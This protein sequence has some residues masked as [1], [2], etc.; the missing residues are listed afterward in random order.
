[1]PRR[2][3]FSFAVLLFLAHGMFAESIT[4]ARTIIDQAFELNEDSD[5]FGTTILPLEDGK[6]LIGGTHFSG[7]SLFQAEENGA[8]DDAFNSNLRFDVHAMVRLKDGRIAVASYDYAF[9]QTG[10]MV[11]RF[12]LSLHSKT[13]QRLRLLY[14]L[15]ALLE[16][17]SFMRLAPLANGGF[18]FSLSGGTNL[19]RRYDSE[20]AATVLNAPALETDR[21]ITAIAANADNSI[22][23]GGFLESIPGFRRPWLWR[24]RP[25]GSRD[26]A[27]PALEPGT[28]DS[29]EFSGILVQP[30]GKAI[31]T[32]DF[33]QLGSRSLTGLARLNPDGTFDDSLDLSRLETAFDAGSHRRSAL[34][35][36]DSFVVTGL[37]RDGSLPQLGFYRVRIDGSVEVFQLDAPFRPIDVQAIAPT[38]DNKIYIIS[39]SYRSDQPSIF[40]VFADGHPRSAIGLA[41]SFL[42]VPETKGRVNV[43]LRRFG[44]TASA[45]EVV[46]ESR[47]K[48]ALAGVHH[49][50]FTNVVRFAPGESSKE[51]PLGLIDDGVISENPEREMVLEVTSSDGRVFVGDYAQLNVTIRDADHPS[52]VDFTFKSPFSAARVRCVGDVCNTES[53]GYARLDS[54]GRI[55]T[56]FLPIEPAPGLVSTNLLLRLTSTGAIER[57]AEIRFSNASEDRRGIEAVPDG[58]LLIYGPL[59]NSN[60]VRIP[61]LVRL[62]EEL[63][64]DPSFTP[65]IAAAE[66]VRA[67]AVLPGGSFIVATD[68][69]R[70]L[71]SSLQRFHA[72]GERDTAFNPATSFGTI[73]SVA[74][75]SDGRVL[76]SYHNIG[77]KVT[78]LHT[79][80]T[81]D[82]TFSFTT[83]NAFWQG[84][85]DLTIGPD[86]TI[87]YNGSDRL[88]RR[89]PNGR[90]DNS[91]RFD[92]NGTPRFGSDGRLFV[93]NHAQVLRLNWD[94]SP[95]A[96]FVPVFS[97]VITEG[98]TDMF[99]DAED[100]PVVVGNF[101]HAGGEL[102]MQIA[103]LN[104]TNTLQGLGFAREAFLAFERGPAFVVVE[105]VADVREAASVKYRVSALPSQSPQNYQ[106]IEG[107]IA[108]APL[109]RR[110]VV[111]LDLA[112]HSMAE[113]DKVLLIQLHGLPP[114]TN[115]G[116]LQAILRILDDDRHRDGLHLAF[117]KAENPAHPGLRQGVHALGVQSDGKILALNSGQYYEESILRLL[118]SGEVDSEFET[119]A[120]DSIDSVHLMPDGKFLVRDYN[121]ISRRNADGT[122]DPNFKFS[123]PGAQIR[124][125]LVTGKGA[126]FVYGRSPGPGAAALLL[127]LNTNGSA[128][129]TFQARLPSAATG[130]SATITEL[131]EDSNGNLLANL[132]WS[133]SSDF[134]WEIVTNRLIRLERDGSLDPSFSPQLSGLSFP[135][136]WAAGPNGTVLISTREAAGERVWRLRGDGAVDPSFAPVHIQLPSESAALNT[137]HLQP[138]GRILLA[139]RFDRC[140]GR[141][142][143]GLVRLNADG[144]LDDEFEL[145]LNEFFGP[146]E[147][148]NNFVG[149]IVQSSAPGE[150][151]LNV[152]RFVRP[153]RWQFWPPPIHPA[154]VRFTST[155]LPR[156]ESISALGTGARIGFDPGT[157]P[158]LNLEYS[159]DLR[160]WLPSEATFSGKGQA[161][162]AQAAAVRRFYRL[163][164]K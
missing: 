56:G 34:L 140:N 88:E 45:A 124:G 62:N 76:L 137:V 127:R 131:I 95:H 79:N 7:L 38:L 149:E 9:S 66:I 134:F 18:V 64:V 91:F 112:D 80:G 148:R 135:T 29:G 162:D 151:L 33:S 78:R 160:V 133:L 75:Q 40:R 55:V 61:G 16:R 90:L 31:L 104:A 32:G 20:G 144:A 141:P 108:F 3:I 1:M 109:E 128:D 85:G 8:V 103:R 46:V 147:H 113:P 130:R 120:F 132:Q 65:A 68:R 152:W 158:Q 145:W 50:G 81:V 13:G 82:S 146:I 110:K 60:G 100:R 74:V 26:A 17:E 21:Y 111:G 115:P 94:G 41:D 70:T 35:P 139:G 37:F 58:N 54:K 71:A 163:R 143:P 12:Y 67:L 116:R 159:E 44:D 164:G 14:Q 22:Y 153:E 2:A 119:Q 86:D 53:L 69:P 98:F 47:D 102:S 156:L 93:F 126:T 138:D 83:Q 73:S 136:L 84:R 15:T 77:P 59:V 96:S 36:D 121:S 157:Y 51:I 101:S 117:A 161:E 72:N 19:I 43:L 142:C 30:D 107:E 25:D 123:V 52:A 114:N 106:P 63:A 42:S 99:L 24:L 57:Q 28:N 92:G 87:Y 105:R 89:L 48:T 11:D 118:P 125:V 27:F 97:A 49:H 5:F 150:Y 4:P 122:R 10:E 23:V 39:G 154:F 6:V 155:W 129:S